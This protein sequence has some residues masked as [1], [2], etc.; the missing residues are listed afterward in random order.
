L[1]YPH[2]I[3]NLKTEESVVYMNK[4]SENKDSDVPETS[5]NLEELQRRKDRFPQALVGLS[6][7]EKLAKASGSTHIYEKSRKKGDNLV[8]L[9]V[10]KQTIR[11]INGGIKKMYMGLVQAGQKKFA[12]KILQENKK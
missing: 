9:A 1:T 10:D 11:A 2:S 4:E 3:A 5:L 7:A 8:I 12:D 6:L